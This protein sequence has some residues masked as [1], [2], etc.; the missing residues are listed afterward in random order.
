M[1]ATA[2]T[3]HGHVTET[4][5]VN[6]APLPPEIISATVGVPPAPPAGFVQ[7]SSGNNNNGG[8]G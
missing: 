3:T 6:P 2:L 5:K 4:I 7:Q 8:T 1:D